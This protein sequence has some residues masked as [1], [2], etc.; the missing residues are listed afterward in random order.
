MGDS[1]V[2]AAAAMVIVCLGCTA[3]ALAHKVEVFAYAS[4][5]GRAIQGEA[6]L[7]GG[8]P[9]RQ[10]KVTVFGPAGQTL[11]EAT[12]DDEGKFTV[13]VRFRCDHR[14][15]LDAGEG[16]T[17]EYTVRADELPDDLPPRDGTSPPPETPAETTPGTTGSGASPGPDAPQRAT[18]IA[19]TPDASL[20]ARIEALTRQVTELRSQLHRY[21]ETTRFRDVLGGIGYIL[22]LAGLAFY[23]LGVRRKQKRDS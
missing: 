3:P 16:H 4:P 18:D 11:G 21:E 7:R 1:P 14:V 15:V 23:F 2:R 22:G 12:T 20:E 5:D 17:A 13:A 8:T 6:Y 9:M 10:A 19:E